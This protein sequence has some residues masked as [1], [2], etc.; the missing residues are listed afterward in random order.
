MG[1]NSGFKGLKAFSRLRA[2]F[3]MHWLN[4][5]RLAVTLSLHIEWGKTAYSKPCLRMVCALVATRWS[6]ELLSVNEVGSAEKAWLVVACFLLLYI[7]FILLE[8]CIKA[9]PSTFE[10]RFIAIYLVHFW[11]SYFEPQIHFR[12]RAIVMDGWLVCFL[13]FSYSVGQ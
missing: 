6:L 2:S 11:V 5:G 12:K 8:R 4:D 9:R 7:C 1:F 13:S 10:V 3:C